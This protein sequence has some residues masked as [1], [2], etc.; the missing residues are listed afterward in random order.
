MRKRLPAAQKLDGHGKK[1]ATKSRDRKVK[2]KKERE[3]EEG[4]GRTEEDVHEL[5]TAGVSAVAIGAEERQQVT[6]GFVGVL[7]LEGGE[8]SGAGVLAGDGGRGVDRH[9]ADGDG[10][11]EV[12]GA[13][14]RG[15]A[16]RTGRRGAIGRPA[17]GRLPPSGGRRGR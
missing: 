11:R 3:R 13:G 5:P 8:E 14:A 1:G 7:G 16:R 17:R 15:G 4:S 10:V 2:K 6:F 9:A 12:E